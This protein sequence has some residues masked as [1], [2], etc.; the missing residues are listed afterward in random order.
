MRCE[1]YPPPNQLKT[2]GREKRRSAIIVTVLCRE[3]GG[4]DSE[5][6]SHVDADYPSQSLLERRGSGGAIAGHGINLY[7]GQYMKMRGCRKTACVVE[8]TQGLSARQKWVRAAHQ[9]ENGMRTMAIHRM[10]GAERSS[11]M[12]ARR[13][14]MPLQLGVPRRTV[15][16]IARV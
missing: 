15:T 9:S 5:I 1:Q 10:R 6:L 14:P 16:T 11:S 2:K 7:R 4:H 3:L 8:R 13:G 12:A